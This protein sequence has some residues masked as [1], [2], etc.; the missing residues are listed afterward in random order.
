MIIQ[1]QD[2]DQFNAYFHQKTLHP[3]ISVADLSEA[4]LS[5]FE[6]TDFNMYCVVLMDTDFGEL[7]RGGRCMRYKPGT[8]FTLRPG[9]VVSMNL[10]PTTKPKGW[11]LAFRTELLIKTGLG[12]DFYMFNYFN[13]DVFDALELSSAERHVLINCFANIFAELHAIDDNLTGHMLRLGVGQLLSYCKRFYERQF[14][15]QEKNNSNIISR[16]SVLLDDYLSSGMPIQKG[17]PTVAWCAE[18]FHLSPNYFG[19]VVKRE[20][21]ITAQEYVQQK[22][23]AAAKVMLRDPRLS[24]SEIAE[25]LGFTYPNHFTRLFHKKTQMSPTEF[26]HTIGL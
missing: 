23:I 20:L 2:I 24:V 19:D 25:A 15:I 6:P 13:Q 22:I 26:R 8:V 7:I 21:H 11:M 14:D 10:D 4:D 16:L 9:Q 1:V 12:R 3:H 18:Q 5:L 17:Q